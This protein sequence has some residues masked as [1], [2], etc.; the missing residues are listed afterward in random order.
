[1]VAN[2]PST[3]RPSIA[4]WKFKDTQVTLNA[5]SKQGLKVGMKLVVT[6]PREVI[7]SV[8]IRKVENERAEGIMTQI[9]EDQPGPKVGWRLSTRAR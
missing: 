5:G 3:T 2:G 6:M 1:V 9:G 8:R 7:E 4:D